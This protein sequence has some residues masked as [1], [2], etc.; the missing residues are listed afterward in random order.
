V[1]ADIAALA[2]ILDGQGK[3]DESEPLYQRA[4]AIF[5]REYGPEHYE[6]AILFLAILA[7]WRLKEKWRNYGEVFIENG[8]LLNDFARGISL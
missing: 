4:L 7:P 5:A 1:V 8:E 2:A 3:Y 6:I